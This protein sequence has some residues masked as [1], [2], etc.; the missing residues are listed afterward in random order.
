MICLI[1]DD[2]KGRVYALALERNVEMY[3]TEF[4]VRM[5]HRTEQSPI[6]SGGSK[7]Q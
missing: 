7:Q 6:P 5:V 1:G 3:S 4:A 2:A